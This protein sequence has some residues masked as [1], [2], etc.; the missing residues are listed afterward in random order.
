M[1]VR[2]T[3]AQTSLEEVVKFQQGRGGRHVQHPHHRRLHVS[4]RDPKPCRPHLGEPTA[5]QAGAVA[6]SVGRVR[7]AG[8]A[9]CRHS[10]RQA[11]LAEIW[12]SCVSNLVDEADRLVVDV[13]EGVAPSID[14]IRC[15]VVAEMGIFFE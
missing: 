13:R 6:I 7:T 10:R 3:P 15:F 11:V 14:R 2:V 5:P 4:Q 8:R 9:S 1:Q 12:S